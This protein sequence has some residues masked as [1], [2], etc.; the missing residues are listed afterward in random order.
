MFEDKRESWAG[1]RLLEPSSSV[2]G[3][4]AAVHRGRRTIGQQLQ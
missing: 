2:A 1:Q 3:Q 4:V